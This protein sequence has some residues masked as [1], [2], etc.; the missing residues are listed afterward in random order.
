MQRVGVC[1][2]LIS[3]VLTAPAE[4]YGDEPAAAS[5]SWARRGEGWRCAPP[6]H[7]AVGATLFSEFGM[8]GLMVRG[9]LNYL[10]LEAGGGYTPYITFAEKLRYFTTWQ[11]AGALRVYFNDHGRPLQHGAKL[12][13]AY[14]SL[15]GSGIF[16]GYA[17]EGSSYTRFGW[18]AAAGIQY[19]IHGGDRIEARL[20]DDAGGNN[21]QL[22]LSFIVHYYLF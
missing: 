9:R 4:G 7:L 21:L 17:V 5:C 11:L 18:A 8:G 20:D 19:F 1:L 14:N 13:Y 22:L 3:V 2:I 6:R 10:A 15:T 12:G 16:G